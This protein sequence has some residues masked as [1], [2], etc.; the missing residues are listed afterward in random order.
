MCSQLN[1][2]PLDDD[3]KKADVSTSAKVDMA[4]NED[5]LLPANGFPVQGFFT[6]FAIPNADG[7]SLNIQIGNGNLSTGYGNIDLSGLSLAKM[8]K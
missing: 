5:M 4:S 2:Y 3:H 1:H 6:G 8:S 7:K